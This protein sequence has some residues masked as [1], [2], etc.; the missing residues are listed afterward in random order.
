[1]ILGYL[2]KDSQLQFMWSLNKVKIVQ[3]QKYAWVSIN[4]KYVSDTIDINVC[5]GKKENIEEGSS[6][7]L[8]RN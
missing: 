5:L 2:S 7:N 3:G 4:T 6:L 1:M 8:G